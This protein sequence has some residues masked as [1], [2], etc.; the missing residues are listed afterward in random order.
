MN[1]NNPYAYRYVAQ[2]A[3]SYQTV[4]DDEATYVQLPRWAS[5]ILIWIANRYLARPYD[6][7]EGE[8]TI[9]LVRCR[10]W[11]DDSDFN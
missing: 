9:T 3:T 11:E 6:R 4:E 5:A 2:L 8:L 10:V 7:Q 1:T